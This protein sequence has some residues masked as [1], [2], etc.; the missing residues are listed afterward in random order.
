ML[1]LEIHVPR[2][3]PKASAVMPLILSHI[4]LHHSGID[5]PFN[6]TLTEARRQAHE[7]D[8]P[9]SELGTMYGRLHGRSR[10][11]TFPC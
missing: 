11:S 10:L 2:L 8:A 1:R 6:I 7:I 3:K 4:P 9:S 5:R